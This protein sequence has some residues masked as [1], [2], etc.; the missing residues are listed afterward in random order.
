LTCFTVERTDENGVNTVDLLMCGDGRWGGLGNNLYSSAQGN[1]IRAKSV[2]GLLEYSEEEQKLQPIVPHAVS[3]SPT[4]HVLLTLETQ[5]R[6]GPGGGG[7]DLLVWGA[8]QQYELGNGKRASLAVPTR[9][10]QA[11]GTHFMLMKAKGDVMDMQGKVWKKGVD[12]EQCGAAGYKNTIV[13]WKI[14]RP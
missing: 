8:N 5:A 6:A 3:V 11:D 1:P 13:Y 2:S 9:L 12:V 4:G 7:R 10:Q 14:C